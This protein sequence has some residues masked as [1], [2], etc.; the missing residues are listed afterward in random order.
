[1]SP[2]SSLLIQSVFFDCFV[3]EILHKI[4]YLAA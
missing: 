2:V 1:M 3:E 4:S